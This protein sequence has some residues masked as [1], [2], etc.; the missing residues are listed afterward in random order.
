M[1]IIGVK[2]TQKMLA[3]KDFKVAEDD[4][5]FIGN[6]FHAVVVERM[7]VQVRANLMG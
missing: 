3:S 4:S 6:V 7:R 1:R 5:G 2:V